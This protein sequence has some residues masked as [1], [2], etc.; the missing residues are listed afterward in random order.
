MRM[1]KYYIVTEESALHRDYF[2]WLENIE[3]QKKMADKLIVEYGV[4]SED[5]AFTSESLHIKASSDDIENF[6]S[7]LTKYPDSEGYYKFKANSKISKQW[8]QFNKDK[9]LINSRKPPVFFYFKLSSGRHRSRLFDR[10]GNLYC[11]IEAD[12]IQE[13]PKGA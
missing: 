4:K 8:I 7:Q 9:G 6:K 13:A 10:D 12:Y 3:A 2:K 5:F 1:E 11:Y